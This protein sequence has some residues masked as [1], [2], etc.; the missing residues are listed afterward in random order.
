M[1]TSPHR[2]TASSPRRLRPVYPSSC[3]A[4]K[5]AP[6]ATFA[7]ELNRRPQNESPARLGCR[8]FGNGD[9]N[10]TEPAE[11]GQPCDRVVEGCRRPRDRPD[12]G[13]E[14]EESIEQENIAVHEQAESDEP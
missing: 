7:M 5:R 4:D 12:A 14:P 11:P 9:N 2:V 8:L 13:D 6:A 10:K 1:S 3:R